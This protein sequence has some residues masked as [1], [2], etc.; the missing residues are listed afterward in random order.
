[1]CNSEFKVM[2]YC[3]M[4]E[5]CGKEYLSKQNLK[6]HINISHLLKKQSK[7]PLCGK[8]FLNSIN[9]KE[10]YL[11]HSN[12]KPYRCSICNLRFRHKSK[13]GSHKRLHNL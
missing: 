13:L 6:R 4:Y 8:T 1:M 12:S 2:L 9:L 7:C 11:I 5:D 10:H 3:C